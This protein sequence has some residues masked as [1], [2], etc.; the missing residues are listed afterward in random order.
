MF[1]KIKETIVQAA[2]EAVEMAEKAFTS[3]EGQLKKQAAIE[4]VVDKI[5]FPPIISFLKPVVVK[6]LSIFI[7]ECIEHAVEIL[8]R[9]QSM[10]QL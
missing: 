2:G 4:F 6:L 8:K 7:D 10:L 5:K 1:E 9:R 3:G